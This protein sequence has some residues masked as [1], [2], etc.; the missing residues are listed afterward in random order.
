LKKLK[1]EFEQLLDKY[2]PLADEYEKHTSDLDSEAAHIKYF[3]LIF[4]L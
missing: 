4:I 1:S 2:M 3:S